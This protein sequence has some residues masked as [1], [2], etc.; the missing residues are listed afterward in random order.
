M[1]QAIKNV[2]IQ[3]YYKV[4][5]NYFSKKSILITGANSGIGKALAQQIAGENV[6]LILTARRTEELVSIAEFCSK[7]G[8]KCFCYYLDVSDENSIEQLCKSLKIEFNSLDILIN[9]AGI[10]QRSIAAET[11]LKVDRLLMETNFFGPVHLTKLLW[12]LILKSPKG[13]IILMSSLTGTFGF[14]LRSAYAASKH[15]IEGFFQSWALENANKNISFTVIAPGRIQTNISYS[16]LKSDGSAHA[17]LDRGQEKGIP[18]SVCAEKII[19]AIIKQKRKVYIVKSERIL[20]F[21]NKY[22][23]SLFEFAVKKL[24]LS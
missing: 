12:P 23:P 3:L 19:K 10:S 5:N 14:T 7:K 15:A 9:N 17:V 16:A 6:Q 13:Q 11:E 22:A 18:A 24:K 2:D 21:L 8:A 4:N 20:L 1:I